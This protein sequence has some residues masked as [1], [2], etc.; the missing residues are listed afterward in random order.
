MS[1]RSWRC[2]RLGIALAALLAWAA[3]ASA[4]VDAGYEAYQRGDYG[5]ALEAWR[6]EARAGVAE[7]QH[8]LAVLYDLGQGIEP[9]KVRAARWYREAAVQGLAAA[10]YNLALMLAKGEGVARDPVRAYMLLDLAAETDREAA[11]E[12]GRLAETMPP[13]EIA[14]GARLARLARQGG[15]AEV[16]RE[17]LTGILPGDA[18]TPEQLAYLEAE[19]SAPVQR[20]LAELGY[21]P[22]PTDGVP[23]PATRAAVRAFQAEAGLEVDGRITQ[24]LLDRLYQAFDRHVAERGLRHGRGRLWRVEAA[25][26]AP[27][28]VF[29]TMHS[30][31]PRVLA[32]PPPVWQAFTRAGALALEIDMSGGPERAQQILGGYFQAML[33]S[34]GRTLEQIIGPDVFADALAA[35]RPYGV[36]AQVLRRLKPWAVYEALVRPPAAVTERGGGVFLDLSLAREAKLRGKPVYGLE[37]LEEQVAVFADIPEQDQVALVESAIAYA[38]E[39]NLGAETLTR[40]YLAGDLGAIFRLW[41]EP[42]R[43][44]GP[45]FTASVIERLFDE[46]NAVMVA[47]MDG[48]LARGNV[49]IAVGA[50]HLPGDTGVLHLLERKGYRVTRVY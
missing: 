45:D 39:E 1:A 26:A 13:G 2:R 21:D 10:Q 48:L 41:V 44:L 42:V 12:R 14:Q 18:Y 5:A 24:A 49:F 35:L 27:S 32:L 15:A 3:P 4:Q 23:G 43:R 16:L 34:D 22:G 30:S 46:R 9:D 19:L 36:S 20:A 11:A 25:E 37:T 31:D 29:G 8:N 28:Y 17:A 33:L 38:G 47:R 50:G 7:A 6:A 40:L